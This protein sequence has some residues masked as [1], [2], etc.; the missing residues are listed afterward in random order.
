[1]PLS[2]KERIVRDFLLLLHQESKKPDSAIVTP[3]AW[4]TLDELKASLASANDDIKT[5]ARAIAKWCKTH[6]HS[7]I[8]QALRPVQGDAID[9]DKDPVDD[10]T[11]QQ[12][13]RLTNLSIRFVEE[14]INQAQTQHEQQS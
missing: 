7:A 5:I 9:E 4:E 6:D 3:Q 11:E 8:L 12:I 10:E 1:M 13:L 14:T 2:E